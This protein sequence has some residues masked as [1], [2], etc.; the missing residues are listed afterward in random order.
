M[1]HKSW[2]E[3][4][5]IKSVKKICTDIVDDKTNRIEIAEAFA[6]EYDTLYSSVPSSQSDLL[7]IQRC[8]TGRIQQQCME[9]KCVNHFNEL[10]LEDID[11][12]IKYLRKYK[13]DG[14]DSTLK[15]NAI[16]HST[17][18]FTLCFTL[19]LTMVIRMSRF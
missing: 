7:D 8:I 14:T 3:I 12:S 15:S 9:N 5:K 16:I 1:W 4:Q 6:D 11:S 18:L 13:S 2:N 10:T 19:C 17:P